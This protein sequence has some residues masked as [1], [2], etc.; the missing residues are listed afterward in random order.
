[1][2]TNFRIQQELNANESNI[3]LLSIFYYVFGGISLLISF[4]FLV[5]IVIIRLI[6]S[7]A[8]V[9][10]SIEMQP[11][12]HV[13]GTVFSFVSIV[14]LFV[15][16]LIVT[17]GILQIVAGTRLKQKRSRTFIIIMAAISLLSFPLG[18][19]LGVFTIIVLTKTSV[20][21]MFRKEEERLREL[22]YG[23]IDY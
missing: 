2:E 8:F 11:D 12:G 22:T 1:M 10:Q 14:F 16:V 7:S 9:K 5:Y 18:T 23:K 15:F 21:D 19:A 20:I 6:M 3:N 13:V 17:I 4:V